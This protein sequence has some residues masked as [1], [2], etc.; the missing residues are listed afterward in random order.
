MTINTY[1]Y[2]A[3]VIFLYRVIAVQCSSTATA[4][5]LIGPIAMQYSFAVQQF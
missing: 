3:T 4:K 2:T 5:D 1:I